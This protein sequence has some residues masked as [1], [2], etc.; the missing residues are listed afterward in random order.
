MQAPFLRKN[1][2]REALIG[3][4]RVKKGWTV[5]ELARRS[6]TWVGDITNMQNGLLSP[7]YLKRGGIKPAAQRI[8]DA[9]G[10]SPED[11]FP[12]YFCALNPAAGLTVDQLPG[13]SEAES[14]QSVDNI[15][16]DRVE[17]D[18]LLARLS[19]RQRD[20]VWMYYGE[21]ETLESISQKHNLT[22]ERVRQIVVKSLS[23]MRRAA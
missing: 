2:E 4:Y 9:L 13:L 22:R 12:R 5:A 10:V 3:E 11:L 17:C 23:K 19:D 8:C 15:L 7:V 16:S 18:R 1:K 6:K 20:I 21:A 14:P